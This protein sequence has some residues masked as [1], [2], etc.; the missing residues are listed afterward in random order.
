MKNPSLVIAVVVMAACATERETPATPNVVSLS[1]ANNAFD[2]PDTINAGWTTFH[3]ANKGDDIHYAHIVQLDSGRTPSELVAAYAEAI[4]TSGPRPKWV[5]RFGGPGGAVP[6]DSSNVTEYLEPGSYVWI[7]PIEDNAGNPHFGKG[8]F[9][10]FVVRASNT[11]TAAPTP[12]A[13]IRLQDFTFAVDTSLRAGTHT[14]RVANEGV[15]PHDLVLMKLA[16]GKTIEDIRMWL[17]PEL[18]RREKPSEPPPSFE[19]LGSGAGG[20]A[21]IGSGMQVFFV[22]NFTPGDYVA[23]CMATA[24]DGRSHIEHGMIQG[25]RIDP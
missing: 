3:F 7:C 16:P 24:P 12:G 22:T 10:P 18:A 9:R 11:E 1:S 13:E 21:A 6:G 4:R 2:A 23:L 20:I 5:R 25:F 19:S 14:I 17:N 8:E 15:E